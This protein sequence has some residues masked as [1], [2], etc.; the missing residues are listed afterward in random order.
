MHHKETLARRIV[1]EVEHVT[2]ERPVRWVALQQ[3]ARRRA[4]TCRRAS[5][6]CCAYPQYGKRGAQ[7][8]QGKS[9]SRPARNQRARRER[10]PWH[11]VGVRPGFDAMPSAGWMGRYEALDGCG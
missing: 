10:S 8:L 2:A 7:D 1:V 9:A 11:V 3:I 5:S 6:T 4:K